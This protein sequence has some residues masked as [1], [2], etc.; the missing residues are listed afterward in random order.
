MN[1]PVTHR[2]HAERRA[3]TT[4]VDATRWPD[5]ASPPPSSRARTAVSQAV[6]RGALDRLPMHVRLADGSQLG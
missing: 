6:V 4:A 3:D 5:V 1:V 2:S